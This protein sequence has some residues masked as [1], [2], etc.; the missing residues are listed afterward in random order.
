MNHD[1]VI[2]RTFK[3]RRLYNG[4]YPEVIALF[5]YIASDRRGALY[6][7]ESYMH[8]GQHG[9]ADYD[10]VIRGTRPATPEEYAPLQRE[11]VG[12]GYQ[13]KIASRRDRTKVSP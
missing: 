5:P 4:N 11:L 12:I 9:S 8:V 6:G 13:L 1:T 10:N 3:K 2:F 7:C